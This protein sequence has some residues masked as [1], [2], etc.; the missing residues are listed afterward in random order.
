VDQ[1]LSRETVDAV[2]ASMQSC[3]PLTVRSSS[4]RGFGK[5]E[6]LRV[7]G[8][9]ATVEDEGKLRSALEEIAEGRRI[10][11]SGISILNPSVCMVKAVM[12]SRNSGPASLLYNSANTGALVQ[13]DALKP[14]DQAVVSFVAPENL[15]GNLYVFIVD[16]EFN[17]F[18][19][20]PMPTRPDT[21]LA[22]IGTVE[23]G[24]R[25]VQLSWP[26]SEGSRSQP[27][28]SF[29]EPYGISM[30]FVVVTN[31]D[32][33]LFDHVRAGGENVRE[34]APV[35][36]ESIKRLQDQGGIVSHIHRFV[37]VDED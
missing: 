16:N 1:R 9:L 33:T 5:T 18:H 19:I 17:A 24:K 21:N 27:V 14:D 25:R 34:L 32:T 23:D 15:D 7:R 31:E 22:R 28:L 13:G 4:S 8:D 35:L 6:S 2:L 36:A 26:M 10:D 29:T 11:T 30:M 3:G 37:L 20:Y 12:P